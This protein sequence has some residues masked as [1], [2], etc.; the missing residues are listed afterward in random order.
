MTAEAFM[1]TVAPCHPAALMCGG[2]CRVF[3]TALNKAFKEGNKLVVFE[4][5]P[6]TQKE[7]NQ[8]NKDIF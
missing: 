3:N 2:H 8:R 6:Q 4:S 5:L 7:E 1:S